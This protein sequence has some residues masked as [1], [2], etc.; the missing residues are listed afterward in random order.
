MWLLF[1]SSNTY[2]VLSV[3]SGLCINNSTCAN[4]ADTTI[5]KPNAYFVK[6]NGND[7]ADGKS[8]ATAWKTTNKVNN[9]H[10]K[11][12]DDVYFLAGGTWTKQILK[13]DWSGTADNRVIIGAY[14]IKHG[15]ETAG[16]LE[17]VDKPTLTGGYTSSTSLGNVPTSTFAGLI[18]ISESPYVT[19]QNMKVKDSS[20]YGIV[21]SASPHAIIENNDVI[22]VAGSS[23]RALAGSDYSIIRNNTMIQ[24]TWSIE[25]GI[26]PVEYGSHPPCIGVK[27]SDYVTVENN[28]LH[29]LHCEAIATV[30]GADFTVMRG[31]LITD[32]RYVGLYVNGSANALVENNIVLGNGSG[33]AVRMSGISVSVETGKILEN[34]TNIVI[35]NNLIAGV[36]SCF[37]TWLHKPAKEKGMFTSG[38]FIG[39]S[40]VGT[41][42]GISFVAAPQHFGTWLVANN[43]VW[44]TA[45]KACSAPTD[46]DITFLNNSWGTNPGDADCDGVGDIYGNPM[47]TTTTDFRDF[48]KDNLATAKDFTPQADSPVIGAGKS[49][50]ELKKDYLGITRANPTSIGA[51]ENI[52]SR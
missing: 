23:A 46:P 52:G 14:H 24:S 4:S 34:A 10:F 47:L 50:T 18:S 19:I 27:Q 40:C 8:H 35:R 21:A 22:R 17:G 29:Q 11:Q 36:T 15:V 49:F 38:V 41:N 48:G 2:S 39:N 1:I 42:N 12:G 32:G 25:D 37:N 16:V 45:D 33:E 28:K 51:I 6:P 44:D 30:G 13:V 5:D 7:D 20:G 26:K 9:F 3:P 31:N 43:L